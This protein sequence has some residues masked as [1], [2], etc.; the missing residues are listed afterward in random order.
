M[1]PAS[2]AGVH[3][4]LEVLPDRLKRLL[5]GLYQAAEDQVARHGYP[6]KPT[7]VA[8]FAPVRAVALALGVKHN[9]ISTW[10]KRYPVLRKVVTYAPYTNKVWNA[11]VQDEQ[12]WHAGAVWV[13]RFTPGQAKM[14][15]EYLERK[16]RDLQRDIKQGET[17]QA[18][19]TGLRPSSEAPEK[20]VVE[21]VRFWSPVVSQPPLELDGRSPDHA[22]DYAVLDAFDAVTAAR[23]AE[24]VQ[25]LVGDK[26][27]S[28]PYWH[29]LI[30]RALRANKLHILHNLL[31]R[32]LTDIRE[33]PGLKNPAALL[34]SRVKHAG[35]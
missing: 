14:R 5:V 34:V 11:R 3:P 13:V 12:D 4:E 26:P 2:W 10:F 28:I 18:G 23:A 7:E 33:W 27:T 25:V 8:F 1:L 19:Y 20:Q 31:T 32:T 15:T 22:V 24:A 30:F 16:W 9:T 21:L 6:V 35:L 29:S 17:I